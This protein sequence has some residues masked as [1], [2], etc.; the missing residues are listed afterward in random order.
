MENSNE[1]NLNKRINTELFRKSAEIKKKN[2][3]VQQKLSVLKK[4][5]DEFLRTGLTSKR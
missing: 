1:N 4:L 3:I 2:N 5:S